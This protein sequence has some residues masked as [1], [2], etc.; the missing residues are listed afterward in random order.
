MSSYRPYNDQNPIIDT[1][2]P[3]AL[4]PKQAPPRLSPGIS[5]RRA[6]RQASF[7]LDR[8]IG[9][10]KSCPYCGCIMRIKGSGLEM[11]TRDHVLPLS[12]GGTAILIVCY[13]C[14][15]RK[16]DIMPD[17]FLETLRGCRRTIARIAMIGALRKELPNG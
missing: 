2:V 1:T 11:P 14:N 5:E 13:G 15:N 9:E 16:G 7:A 8:S 3:P 12:K 4:L 6:M 10:G 17:L